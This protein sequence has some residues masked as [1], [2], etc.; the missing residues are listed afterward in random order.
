MQN[1]QTIYK[2]TQMLIEK[3]NEHWKNVLKR[4]IS[5]VKLLAKHNLAFRGLNVRLY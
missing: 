4:I 3:E 1:F 2:T 5:I